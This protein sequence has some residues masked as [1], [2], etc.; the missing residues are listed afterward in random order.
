MRLASAMVQ[1]EK[2]P[3]SLMGL[4][5]GPPANT[6]GQALNGPKTARCS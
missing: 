2:L 5:N 4:Q 3:V 6:S 1:Y